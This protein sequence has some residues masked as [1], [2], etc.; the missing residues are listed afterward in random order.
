MNGSLGIRKGQIS[1]MNGSLGIRKGHLRTGHS[2]ARSI[3]CEPASDMHALNAH[4]SEQGS[5]ALLDC[6]SGGPRSAREPI[7]NP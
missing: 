6:P 2:Q 4:V 1:G 3:W 7:G 5:K